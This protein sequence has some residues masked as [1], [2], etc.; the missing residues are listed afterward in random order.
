[1]AAN[2]TRNAIQLEDVQ[3]G[4]GFD[5]A[6][7]VL[8]TNQSNGCQNTAVVN[9]SDE[10]IMPALSLAATDNSICD[11]AL[12]VPAVTFNGTVTATVT[13]MVGALIDYT[14]AFG[15][16]AGVAGSSPNHNTFNQLNGGITYDAT[17]THSL[18]GC[19]SAPATV[20]V[21]NNQNTPDITTSSDGSTNCV[22]G[23]EDGQA[24]V[25]LQQDLRFGTV[26]GRFCGAGA[27]TVVRW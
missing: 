10:K 3:G 23:L 17:A 7:T 6:Y 26:D 8:V 19:V 14:F 21:L 18:T 24:P 16:G 20:Q 2:G 5:G 15:G 27:T 25:P 9:V 4:A 22:A 1:M 12:T 11:P 13:N